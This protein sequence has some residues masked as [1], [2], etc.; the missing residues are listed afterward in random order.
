[1]FCRCVNPTLCNHY[2]ETNKQV[3]GCG[4]GLEWGPAGGCR[5]IARHLIA[6]RLVA[7]VVGDRTQAAVAGRKASFVCSSSLLL[8]VP[9]VRDFN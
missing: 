1:V 3:L 4:G 8:A 9:Q 5:R 2:D 7:V 6:C